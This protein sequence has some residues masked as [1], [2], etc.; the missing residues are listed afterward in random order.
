MHSLILNHQFYTQ[1]SW[2]STFA[3]GDQVEIRYDATDE[4]GID[5]AVFRFMS[6][7]NLLTVADHDRDGTA[8]YEFE[9]FKSRYIPV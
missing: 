4:T 3:P 7:G 8:F 5:G 1:L 6:A 9:Q 2:W